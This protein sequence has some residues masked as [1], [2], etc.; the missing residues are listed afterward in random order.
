MESKDYIDWWHL[1]EVGFDGQFEL[2]VVVVDPD[3][4][5]LEGSSKQGTIDFYKGQDKLIL[6]S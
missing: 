6:K 4:V 1:E 5:D 3:W 2:R